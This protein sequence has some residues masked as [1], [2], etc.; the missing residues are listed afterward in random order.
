MA[1]NRE[2]WMDF[3]KGITILCVVAYHSLEGVVNSFGMTEPLGIAIDFLNVWIMP[4]FF[5]ISG[6]LSQYLS[7]GLTAKLKTKVFDYIYI[8]VV[9]SIIIYAVRLALSSFA[10]SPILW[11]EIF[12]IAWNPVPTIWFVYALLL[13]LVCTASL[14]KVNGHLIFL[15][16]I[17]INLCNSMW[18]NWF[19]ESIF[20]RFAWIFCFFYFGFYYRTRI[21]QVTKYLNPILAVFLICNLIFF[22]F[23]LELNTT[24]LAPFLSITFCLLLITI[25][26]A[27]IP[28]LNVAVSQSIIYLGFI[29]LYIYL[30]HFPFPAGIRI[31]LLKVEFYSLSLHIMLV[32][33]TS[34]LVGSL[35]HYFIKHPVVGLLINRPRLLK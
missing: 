26:R 20:Q 29:S 9:W 35:F 28:L 34:A 17:I 25:V 27:F 8:Y 3:V 15:F 23:L 21:I 22:L 7:S 4:I 10:N 13:C 32:L 14:Y 31:L 1:S 30:S 12:Y 33:L 2:V 5:M 16:A 18:P 11:D 19:P 6:M 24:I